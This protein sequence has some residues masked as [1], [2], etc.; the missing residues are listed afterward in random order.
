MGAAVKHGHHRRNTQT[1][2]YT[3]WVNMK[4]RCTNPK[5]KDWDSYGGRGITVCTSWLASFENFLADMGESPSGKTIDRIDNDGHYVKENCRWATGE[6]QR[7]NTSR[8]RWLICRG[9]RRTISEW[10]K[11]SGYDVSTVRDRLKAGLSTEEALFGERLPIP[12]LAPKIYLTYR[13]ETK[14][15]RVWS[16]ELGVKYDTMWKRMRSGF[17]PEEVVHGRRKVK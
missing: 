17:T 16:K 1:R 3:V 7:Q 12:G 15:L 5:N 13:G 4:Q 14:P 8:N 10:C 6:Q 11:L 9:E 2:T